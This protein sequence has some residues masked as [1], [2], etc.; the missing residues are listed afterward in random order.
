MAHK[1]IP[2]RRR[3]PTLLHD[4][5]LQ[6]ILSQHGYGRNCRMV[7]FHERRLDGWA[8]SVPPLS[9][10]IS[11]ISSMCLPKAKVA[12][13]KVLRRA[14]LF[15][16]CM[17]SSG[18]T[19]DNS[20]TPQGATSMNHSRMNATEQKCVTKA[21]GV[22]CLGL[23]GEAS[24]QVRGPIPSTP[25]VHAREHREPE[26]QN[27]LG[28]SCQTTQ[29][30]LE[31]CLRLAVSLKTAATSN[32]CCMASDSRCPRCVKLSPV[33]IHIVDGMLDPQTTTL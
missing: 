10:M 14:F 1:I 26:H 33:G 9:S 29:L 6:T 32:R 22:S 2:T 7:S 13:T 25:P 30:A 20:R 24:L 31:S 27:I 21:A 23:R 16:S 17:C 19:N 3:G 15:S 5:V 11:V 12:A 4:Y 28:H 8:P 18:A